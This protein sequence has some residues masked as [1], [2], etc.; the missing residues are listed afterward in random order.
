LPAAFRWQSILPE[1]YFASFY[2]KPL[3]QINLLH[4]PPTLLPP[5]IRQFGLRPHS[6]TT[7]FTF[8]GKAMSRACRSAGA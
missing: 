4:Y 2:R 7:A 3:T 1:E 5:E 6:D 8:F